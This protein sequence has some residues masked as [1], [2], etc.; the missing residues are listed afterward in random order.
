MIK[1]QMKLIVACAL[2]VSGMT[3]VASCSSMEDDLASGANGIATQ[4]DADRAITFGLTEEERADTRVAPGTIT[5]DGSD[6]NSWSLRNKG[7]GIFA[8]HTGQHKLATSTITSNFM[9]NQGIE[10]VGTQWTYSPVKY[11]PVQ[12]QGKNADYISFFAYAPYAGNPGASSWPNHCITDFSLP[13][14]LGLPWLTYKLADDPLSSDDN[15]KQ[16]DLLFAASNDEQRPAKNYRVS[17]TFRHALGLFANVVNTNTVG[18]NSR[19]TTP[20]N[21][22]NTLYHKII[23]LK[24]QTGLFDAFIA[25]TK[26][27]FNVQCTTQ[28]RL[29]LSTGTNPVW[30]PIANGSS[31]GS[32]S[33]SINLAPTSNEYLPDTYSDLKTLV[34]Q[35][36]AANNNITRVTYRENNAGLFLIPL[37]VDGQTQ[38]ASVVGE[39][40][41]VVRKAGENDGFISTF[42]S[43]LAAP[44]ALNVVA[45]Q[46]ATGLPGTL[47]A[48]TYYMGDT[49]QTYDAA[50][51]STCPLIIHSAPG[52]SVYDAF[53]IDDQYYT[54]AQIRPQMIVYGPD[55]GYIANGIEGYTIAVAYANNVNAYTDATWAT[56]NYPTATATVSK[57]GSVVATITKRFRISN[58]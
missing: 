19:T 27:T 25:L 23:R 3:L 30:Q 55:G 36:N 1:R 4:D 32:R 15:K 52:G 35:P 44:T 24:Q 9:Y 33:Y 31:Y 20:Y 12:E 46:T 37:T 22:I 41:L 10:Y 50:T 58:Y 48:N 49:E 18:Y 54:G 21:S 40:R 26:L 5:T 39:Y 17:F 28:G 38:K 6:G 16:V 29:V 57:N 2:A 13:Y 8:S 53:D 34:A 7:F 47:T 56:P 51:F 14:E 43:T 42:K 45:G 11:W